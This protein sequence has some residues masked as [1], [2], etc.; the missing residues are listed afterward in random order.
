MTIIETE[1]L[2]LRELT[3]EDHEGLYPIYQDPAVHRFIGGPPPPFD[4]YWRTVRERWPA[5]YGEHGFGLWAVIRKDDGALLGR[6]GLL[7]QEVDG[8]RE[9]EVAYA[10]GQH[11]WGRGYATEAARACRDWA[12]THLDVGYVIS[13]IIPENANSIR[14]AGKNGMTFW[15]EA[16]FRTFRVHVYRIT[17]QEWEVLA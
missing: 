3:D 2:R 17:R 8:V 16:E 1:R 6:I 12:F 15:K 10:L 9:V 5:Y 14:V 4:E 7:S 13:L 11:A